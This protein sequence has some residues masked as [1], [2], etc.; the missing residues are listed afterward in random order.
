M[1]PALKPTH[2]SS[3]LF[4][5]EGAGKQVISP[6]TGLYTVGAAT[7]YGIIL[8]AQA[9]YADS[10]VRINE[11]RLYMVIKRHTGGAEW[12]Q[13]RRRQVQWR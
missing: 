1:L 4:I 12:Q 13:R 6:D 2:S 8:A 10:P 11:M 3:L 5:S 9:Q 7:V